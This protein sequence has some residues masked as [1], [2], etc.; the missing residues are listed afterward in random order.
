SALA[1]EPLDPVVPPVGDVE[2]SR[3]IQGEAPG[4]L[5]LAWL[6]PEPAP[7]PDHRARRI[8]HHDPVVLGIGDVPEAFG[9]DDDGTRTAK[10]RGLRSL[11]RGRGREVLGPELRVADADRA[12]AERR[13]LRVDRRLVAPSSL[14]WEVDPVRRGLATVPAHME[15]T[16]LF[17]SPSPFH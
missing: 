1:R 14:V 12:Q 10:A 9:V 5:E 7:H 13:A 3:P 11:S 8:K 4:I 16:S 6:P 2:H 17:A 15:L